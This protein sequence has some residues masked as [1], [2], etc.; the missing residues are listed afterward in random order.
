MGVRDP[1][2]TFFINDART[3]ALYYKILDKVAVITGD[4]LCSPTQY[5]SLLREFRAFCKSHDWSVAVM[6]ASPDLAAL[7]KDKKWITMRFGVEKSINPMTS[8]LLLGKGGK[9]TVTK[10][11]QLLK[12]GIK[13][14]LYCPSYQHDPELEIEMKQLY[15]DWR[16]TRNTERE[17][18]AFMTVFDIL[19]LPR[20]M[21][22]LYARDPLTGT[23]IG[24]AA[25]RKLAHN[26]FHIDPLIAS[27][28]APKGTTD[29]LLFSAMAFC[30][31]AGISK[32]SLGFEP[33]QELSEEDISGMSS[34]M[35]KA[36]RKVHKKMW[37]DLPLGGKKAFHE[38]W[39]TDEELD[40]D[41]YIVFLGTPGLRH[42]LAMVHFANI[43]LRSMIA[44]HVKKER[45]KET[46]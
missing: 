26:G 37:S 8:P 27:E 39:H 16:Q 32:L 22:F 33:K 13:V 3:G 41:L 21:T 43:S 15:D 2:Y 7:A 25:L 35:S 24:F 36:T 46:E 5:E 12:S 40:E 11:K 34:F 1:S 20:L 23:I 10:C 18:Q 17:V 6:A 29:L 30:N 14:Q 28:D 45:E 31:T 9:R 4:P 19:A 44:S 42:M 38:R